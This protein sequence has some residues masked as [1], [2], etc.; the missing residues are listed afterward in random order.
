MKITQLR[1]N[2]ALSTQDLQHSWQQAHSQRLL[3]LAV[4]VHAALAATARIRLLG[5]QL[6][7]KGALT[8]KALS[9]HTCFLRITLLQATQTG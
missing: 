3:P 2:G 8:C 7:V 4:Q 5:T 1:M 6:G 9:I